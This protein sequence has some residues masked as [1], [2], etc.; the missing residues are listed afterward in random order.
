MASKI[1]TLNRELRNRIKVG[2]A[3]LWSHGNG[4]CF[5]LS[6]NGK[7]TWVFRYTFD[8]KRRVMTLGPHNDPISDRQ[9]KELEMAAIEHRDQVKAG[10]DPLTASKPKQSKTTGDGTFEDVARD[11]IATHSGNWRN[12][13]HR[14]QW[15]ATLETYVYPKIGRKLPHEIGVDDVLAVLQQ[16]HIRRGKRLPLWDAVPET[17]SRVRMRIETVIAAAKS[18]SMGSANPDIKAMWKDH[19][20]P[21]KWEDGLEHWLGKGKQSKGHH[22]AMAFADVPGFV[23]QLQTKT[24]FSAKA[25]LLTIL[26]ATRTSETLLATW[27]EFDLE[28]ATWTIPADRMKAGVEH[29]VPLSSAAITLLKGLHR[30]ADNPY[31]FPGAKRNQPLSNMAMLEMLRGMRDGLTV[32]GF[33]SAFRDWAAETTLHPDTIAEMALAHTIKDKTVAAYRRGDA[34]ERRKQLMQQWADFLL[35]SNDNYKQEWQRLIA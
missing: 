23:Q 32:H 15:T 33:R 1:D 22:A 28:A 11:Y 24:D 17:A 16:Q 14:A 13:K 25:L 8:G 20:N 2:Q 31:V 3:N 34:F 10:I 12:D 30:I 35:I 26:C 29:R 9:F 6:A 21:A 18:K 5:A 7:P 4:L 19:H 27:D